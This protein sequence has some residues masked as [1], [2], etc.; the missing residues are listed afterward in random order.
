MKAGRTYA[1]ES[2]VYL[3]SAQNVNGTATLYVECKA[4]PLFATIGGGSKTLQYRGNDISLD[5]SGS[6]DADHMA[7]NK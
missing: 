6:Y 7:D 5:G 2:T 3:G 4:S 1:F